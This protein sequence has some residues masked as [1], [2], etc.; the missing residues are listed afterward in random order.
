MR[1]QSTNPMKT[2]NLS[3]ILDMEYTEKTKSTVLHVHKLM[4]DVE[5]PGFDNSI[6][7]QEQPFIKERKPRDI[8]CEF[9]GDVMHL[10]RKRQ[11]SV[12]EISKRFTCKK[13]GFKHNI[14]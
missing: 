12:D 1:V 4:L 7:L 2:I 14:M 13:V 9:R 11:L 5:V 10:E 8:E 3:D 6:Y